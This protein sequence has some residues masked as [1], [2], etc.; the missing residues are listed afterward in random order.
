MTQYAIKLLSQAY[1]LW[2]ESSNFEF[3]LEIIL[4]LGF[5]MIFSRKI[6]FTL[7]VPQPPGNNLN[8][9]EKNVVPCTEKKT[10]PAS[11]PTRKNVNYTITW[12]NLTTLKK[13]HPLFGLQYITSHLPQHFCIITVVTTKY[14]SKLIKLYTL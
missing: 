13:N 7:K 12:K 6:L 2:N 1:I 5:F 9:P 8:V 3:Y 11:S 4:F 14:I 10:N